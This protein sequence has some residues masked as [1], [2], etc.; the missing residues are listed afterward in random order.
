MRPRFPGFDPQL[1]VH[2]RNGD[3][4][5]A[6]LDADPEL[7]FPAS[8]YPTRMGGRAFDNPD[9][10]AAKRECASCYFRA[11]CLQDALDNRNDYGVF[12]GTTGLERQAMR[13]RGYRAKERARNNATAPLPL[14]VSA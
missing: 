7:F 4:K 10:A 3:P 5:K 12:G 14:E 2:D 1:H 11:A 13:Q 9:V 6:C 8:E